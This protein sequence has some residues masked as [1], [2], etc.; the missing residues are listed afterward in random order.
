LLNVVGQME[1]R[2]VKFII[3]DLCMRRNNAEQKQNDRPNKQSSLRTPQGNP[4]HIGPF[5]ILFAF[6]RN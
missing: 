4:S 2:I 6:S 3:A 5:Q 1:M